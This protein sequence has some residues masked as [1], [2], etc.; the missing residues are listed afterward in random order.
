MLPSLDPTGTLLPPI[1]RPAPRGKPGEKD[2][3][4]KPEDKKPAPGVAPAAA[5]RRSARET[6]L[7]GNMPY[8]ERY[9]GVTLSRALSNPDQRVR[10]A[11]AVALARMNPPA[12]Y[13]GHDKVARILADALSVASK[14]VILLVHEN[15]SERNR[16]REALEALGYSVSEARDG[17]E[18]LTA[19]LQYPP[20]DMI[21]L[22]ANLERRVKTRNVID[23]LQEDPR[24]R[25]IP[26]AIIGNLENAAALKEKFGTDVE[27]IPEQ[28]KDLGTT[29]GEVTEATADTLGCRRAAFTTLGSGLQGSIVR[30]ITGKG[31]GQSRKILKN[32]KTT[33]TVETPWQIIPDNGSTFE[34]EA[35][36]NQRLQYPIEKMLTG[37][38]LP[39]ITRLYSNQIAIAAAI[40]LAEMDPER[41]VIVKEDLFSSISSVLSSSIS[42]D[43]RL[44]LI[45]AA[46]NLKVGAA[47]GALEDIAKNT[48]HTSD[49]RTAA[50]EALAH[51]SPGDYIELGFG[52]ITEGSEDVRRA[53]SELLGRGAFELN[54]NKVLK[55]ALDTTPAPFSSAPAPVVE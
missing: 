2:A 52:L 28:F 15:N 8:S 20:K 55:R 35:G 37:Q 19:A 42:N 48:Q 14:P 16:I 44:Q 3:D 47:V 45:K 18:G 5:P 21:I 22:D 24:T 51:I 29:K 25:A 6:I 32:D 23:A 36:A 49:I 10:F 9:E 17:D 39:S 4:A 40:A 38:E 54:D 41:T 53:I 33:L 1:A 13:E 7:V 26:Y 43:L 46:R 12:K 31:R 50:V 30:I 27:L 34:I 11:A